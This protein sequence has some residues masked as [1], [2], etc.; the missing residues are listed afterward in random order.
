[1]AITDL[2]RTAPIVIAPAITAPAQIVRVPTNQV[3]AVLVQT[4]MTAMGMISR[5]EIALL[6]NSTTSCQTSRELRMKQLM[7][8][9]IVQ[10]E[11]IA[12]VMINRAIIVQ[13]KILA[14]ALA[15]TMGIVPEW[16]VQTVPEIL[17][18]SPEQIVRTDP[19]N[20]IQLETKT[21]RLVQ[22]SRQRI[23]IDLIVRTNQELILIT[24]QA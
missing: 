18:V 11:V 13:D 17:L 2:A 23:L 15:T 24:N 8:R 6:A 10:G 12:Q 5:A 4:T 7:I 9:M 20:L 22:T 1:M 14:I 3:Q 21:N 19:I 16:I